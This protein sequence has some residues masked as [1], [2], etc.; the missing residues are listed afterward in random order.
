M[1]SIFMHMYDMHSI[2]KGAPVHHYGP[3]NVIH[4]EKIS[5]GNAFQVFNSFL[6]NEKKFNY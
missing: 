6:E 1:N 5:G 2:S 4:V 3:I